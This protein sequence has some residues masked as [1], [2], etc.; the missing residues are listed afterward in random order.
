MS[1]TKTAWLDDSP[2][3]ISAANLNNM[4]D[5]IANAHLGASYFVAAVDASAQELAHADYL[6]DGTADDVQ[7]QQ[8]IDAMSATGG[9]VELSSGT[10]TVASKILM[11]SNIIL[12]GQGRNVSFVKM[13]DSVTS[14]SA[15]IETASFQAL[16]GTNS[17]S[18]EH[19]FVVEHIGL[20]GN[21]GNGAGGNGIN[22]Y[23]YSFQL[24]DLAVHAASGVGVYTEWGNATITGATA[25]QLIATIRDF[26]IHNCGSWGLKM[27]GPHDSV[28]ENGEVYRNAINATNVGNIHATGYGTALHFKTVHAWGAT[29]GNVNSWA[30]ETQ[31]HLTDCIGEGGGGANLKLSGS[32]CVINGGSFFTG[33]GS[34]VYGVEIAGS[35]SNYFITMVTTAVTAGAINFTADGGRGLIILTA[36]SAASGAKIVKGTPAA[37][38]LIIYQGPSDAAFDSTTN[39]WFAQGQRAQVQD[40]GQPGMFV[41]PHVGTTMTAANITANRSYFSRFVPSRDITVTKIAIAVATSATSADSSD[42]GIYNSS[43]TLLASSGATSIGLNSTGAKVYTLSSPVTLRAGT[44]YYVAFAYGPIGGTAANIVGYNGAFGAGQMFGT[45]PPNLEWFIIGSNYPL[46]TKASFTGFAANGA[47]PLFAVRES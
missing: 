32:G 46:T 10:F 23:G 16:S 4:E 17:T 25:D 3:Y 14:A 28:I 22:I 38:T 35:A 21:R 20:E 33:S 45:S 15:I 18:G 41:N 1:Y 44:V 29:S 13:A 47:V 34:D 5:G 37:S 6:C 19:H 39:V 11:R 26:S 31:C 43:G 24:R 40:N 12:S 2:P 27:Q 36:T 7:I 9:R 8:A 42:V 30:I